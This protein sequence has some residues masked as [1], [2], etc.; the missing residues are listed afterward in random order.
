[1][2]KTLTIRETQTEIVL[3][4]RTDTGSRKHTDEVARFSKRGIGYVA[5]GMLVQIIKSIDQVDDITFQVNRDTYEM[6]LN[7]GV[8]GPL[9]D[10]A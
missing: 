7:V 6:L 9:A 10:A 5:L 8:I 1:M 3:R 2:H 4:M